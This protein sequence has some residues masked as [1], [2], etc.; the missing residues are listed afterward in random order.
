[1]FTLALSTFT[2]LFQVFD[3]IERFDY[4]FKYDPPRSAVLELVLLKTV[5]A[6]PLVFPV[7][8]LLAG[9]ATLAILNRNS[10]LV[11]MRASG[12]GWGRIAHPLF[13]CGLV[14]SLGV[15]A[16][17]EWV[18][19]QVHER[20]RYVELIQVRKAQSL[21]FLKKDQV[22]FKDGPRV[23]NI[24]LFLPSEGVLRGLT[25]YELDKKARPI[26]RLAAKQGRIQNGRWRFEGVYAAELG[27][28]PRVVTTNVDIPFAYGLDRLAVLEK[29][30]D[31]MTFTELRGFIR[32]L[33]QEHLR[34][35]TYETDLQARISFSLV[36][37]ILALVGIPFAGRPSRHGG[38]MLAVAL[39]VVVGFSYWILFSLSIALGKN[40]LWS[41]W[42]AAWSPNLTFGAGAIFFYRKMG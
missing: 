5:A 8:T 28:A 10:E 23:Y 19:P 37:L 29:R 16:L 39:A 20:M 25:L 38:A 18:L 35:H 3:F 12:I 31:E 24:D 22:W 26:R 30:P 15:I 40:G 7:A 9:V 21:T 27:A 36:S 14:I 34:T 41:P 2:V 13:W 32:K 33:R 42:L 6:L 17:N 4:Y 11:A 1:M